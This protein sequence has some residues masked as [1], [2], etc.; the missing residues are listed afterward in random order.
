MYYLVLKLTALP[1]VFKCDYTI[2]LVFKHYFNSKILAAAPLH[3]V[4]FEN[5]PCVN[6]AA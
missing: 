2:L 6:C 1:Q 3:L 4:L 5:L